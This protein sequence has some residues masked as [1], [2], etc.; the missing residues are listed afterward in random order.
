MNESDRNL[1][2]YGTLQKEP[3]AQVLTAGSLRAELINGNIRNISYDGTE[4][5][6]AI[7]YL[8]RDKDWG[9][10]EP[11]LSDIDIS[12][13]QDEFRVSYIA[14]CP[15][16]EATRLLYKASI[17]GNKNGN[18]VFDVTAGP[19]TD[20]ETNRCG[21][22]VLHPIEGLAGSNITVEHV[23]GDV[24]KTKLPA[25]IDPW[26]PFKQM[27]AI[28]HQVKVGVS[29]ECRMEGDTFEMEDQRNWSDASYKT[30]VR[31]LELP[32]PY[33]L[34]AGSRARQTVRMKILDSRIETGGPTGEFTEM[35]RLKPASTIGKMPSIGI[36]IAP[37]DAEASLAELE[38]LRAI[39]PQDLL[40][41]FDPDAGHGDDALRKFAEIANHGT[42]P[43]TLEVAL[44]CRDDP[45]SE[46]KE[47]ASMIR[48]S[49]M[50]LSG[51]IVSPSVD[52]QSTPPG[53]EWP[54]C[55][56][57]DEVYRAARNAFP[58][59]VLGGGMLSYFTELNRKRVP[60][61]QLDF[62]T[63]STCP[64]VHA[65]D[66]LSVVQTLEALPFITRSVRAIYGDI[67]YRIGPSTIAMRQNP[68]GSSTKDN[69]EGKRIA[70]ANR[71]PRHNG[72]YAAAW[73]VGYAARTVTANPE[74]LTLSALTGPF[75]LIT[76]KDEPMPE[77]GYRPLFHIIKGLA[78]VAA[79]TLI[80]CTSTQSNKI[81]I[82]LAR[83]GDSRQVA[84]LANLAPDQHKVDISELGFDT[85]AQ[86]SVL[87]EHTAISASNGTLETMP[88]QTN[89]IVLNA[90]AVVFVRQEALC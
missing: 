74:M 65:A 35:I 67:P 77:H 80:E 32:W 1:I 73:S 33:A 54:E 53:G 78:E 27:R 42:I 23:N 19:E 88:L 36:V 9:T 11:I 4:V 76:G 16:P 28:T 10:Y 2:L 79:W 21:F 46:L 12:Q 39:S 71:D 62:I 57:L 31:P 47:L 38:T 3:K 83:G 37:E 22:C 69:P 26:Q 52:R 25:L 29:A 66:D 85:T 13:G 70:M 14:R 75:G 50:R 51:I 63:H 86:V 18:L 81:A 61:A 44:P 72:L 87:D 59:L 90:F 89:M 34:P 84:I 49:G 41:H 58:G 24:V 43:A 48:E 17:A 82:V 40:F 68:Y 6:R 7:S 60:A 55:P 56:P 64:L 8:V 15:G 20:F 45:A 5:L 30:Y